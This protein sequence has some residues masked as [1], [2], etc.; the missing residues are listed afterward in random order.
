[1]KPGSKYLAPWTWLEF[2]EDKPAW[3][4]DVTLSERAI[5]AAMQTSDAAAA[6]AEPMAVLVAE[7]AELL[8]CRLRV[9]SCRHAEQRQVIWPWTGRTAVR[10]E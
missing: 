9:R 2:G 6:A 3:L 4:W 5:W 10:G 7:V 8:Q 1:M